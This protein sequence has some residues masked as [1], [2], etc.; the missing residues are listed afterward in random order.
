MNGESLH[1]PSFIGCLLHQTFHLV[2]WTKRRWSIRFHPSLVPRPSYRPV[3]DCL[4]YAKTEGEGLVHF[5]TWMTFHLPRP[6]REN[7]FSAPSTGVWMFAKQK[8]RTAPGSKRRMCAQNMR[9]SPSIFAC[10]K[11][12][13]TGW[14]EGLG[15]RLVLAHFHLHDSTA[16]N[17]EPFL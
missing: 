10:C 2:L 5:I 3:F 15:T 1:L 13:K 12:S 14:W 17:Y 11:R 7:N 16:I 8:K 6:H 9:S 4:Q